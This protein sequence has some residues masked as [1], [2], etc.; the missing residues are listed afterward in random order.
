MDI[1]KYIIDQKKLDLERMIIAWQWLAGKDKT[2]MLITK[3]GH[4][5]LTDAAGILYFLNTEE[6]S[7]ETLSNFQAD[8]FNN[9]L[10]AE[11]YFEIFQP[12]L[13]KDLEAEG[14]QLK[15][16]QVFAYSRLPSSGRPIQLKNRQAANVYEYFDKTGVLHKELNDLL[17]AEQAKQEKL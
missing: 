13:I 17:E 5:L 7:M 14:K 9:K 3:M 1:K 12:E 8:F 2:V 6:G 15:E 10:S 11:Q 4:L 16:A